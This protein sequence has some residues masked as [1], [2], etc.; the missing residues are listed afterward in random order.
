MVLRVCMCVRDD[1]HQ[2]VPMRKICWEVF[3]D[4]VLIGLNYRL[5]LSLLLKFSSSI[6]IWL[7]SVQNAI[8]LFYLSIGVYVICMYVDKN[9]KSISD[10]PSLSL[11]PRV[12]VLLPP[13]PAQSEVG[14]DKNHGRRHELLG[15]R[16]CR[17]F[18]FFFLS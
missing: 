1:Q 17:V 2:F 7:F 5:A 16:A 12:S 15:A 14:D 6:T 4:F 18:I 11:S 13:R 9:K 8:P 10:S 3:F